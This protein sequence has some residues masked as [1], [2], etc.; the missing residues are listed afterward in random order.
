[1]ESIKKKSDEIQSPIDILKDSFMPLSKDVKE[2]L[3]DMNEIHER[4]KTTEDL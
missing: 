2:F 4:N 1:M 3:E